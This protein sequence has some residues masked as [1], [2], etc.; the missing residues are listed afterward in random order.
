MDFELSRT[1]FDD[2]WCR[3]K[4]NSL[5]SLELSCRQVQ[6]KAH[7]KAHYKAHFSTFHR[8]WCCADESLTL[9]DVQGW[10]DWC[11]CARGGPQGVPLVVKQS[12]GCA[13][14]AFQMISITYHCMTWS[15]PKVGFQFR[16]Q[17]R[18]RTTHASMEHW[19]VHLIAF[20]CFWLFLCLDRADKAE[21]LDMTVP[22]AL[23]AELRPM[24]WF[25]GDECY[26]LLSYNKY[27]RQICMYVYIYLFSYQ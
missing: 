20:E 16:L 10:R 26:K 3:S 4:M 19:H 1:V 17:F 7:Y 15:Y 27:Y 22:P 13:D 11:V 25:C 2:L 14:T 8:M 21:A 9:L 12:L 5:R 23:Q 6:H 24:H 18:P